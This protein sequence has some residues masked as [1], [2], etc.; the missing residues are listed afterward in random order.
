MVLTTLP[1][2]KIHIIKLCL[3]IC[4]TRCLRLQAKKNLKLFYD[5]QT[6]LNTDIKYTS[7]QGNK[8]KKSIIRG[9]G[10]YC[11]APYCHQP[12]PDRIYV[13]LPMNGS[14][15]VPVSSKDTGSPRRD[16][17]GASDLGTKAARTALDNAGW[18]AD[19]LDFYHFCHLKPGYHVSRGRLPSRKES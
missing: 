11:T 8:M 16:V 10:F 15:S 18:T 2:N 17:C 14:A 6:N 4:L 1:K 13:T 9:S 12:G 3:H 19:D 5:C 7:T